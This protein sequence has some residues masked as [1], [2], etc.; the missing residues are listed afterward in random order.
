MP[1]TLARVKVKSASSS[2]VNTFLER[3]TGSWMTQALYVAAKLGI[4]DLLKNGP[5]TCED[6]AAA[7]STQASSLHR[8]LRALATI[9]ICNET[10][11]GAFTLAP[12]GSFLLTDGAS[13]LRSWTIWW[14]GHLW[15]AW[16]NL[17]HS[18]R[19]GKSARKLLTGKDGFDHLESNAE[20]A[21]LF[22]RAMAELTALNSRDILRVYDFSGF[23]RITDIGGGYGEFLLFILRQHPGVKGVVF[24]LPR[25][26]EGG[27]R[28]A[29]K[30]GLASRCEFLT[31][32]FFESI[33]GGADAYL[34]KNVLHDW[35]DEKSRQILENCRRS[36]D[37]NAR[38]LVIEQ[39]L[40]EQRGIS[41]AH[42]AISQN[43]LTM[44]VAHGAQ[45]RTE[46]EY[47]ALLKSAG[48]MITRTLQ[49]GTGICTIEAFPV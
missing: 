24:D 23:K 1:K 31:G 26:V 33:P 34:L 12:M 18:V 41:T 36:M 2:P 32:D 6:L 42:Q 43:D 11:D 44:L 15:P 13:S 30:A 27:R 47:K 38:L 4:A 22:D 46:R 3:L 21:A 39:L 28:H 9:E 14:G 35:N 45:E 16:G 19:T 8:L 48:F 49:T 5:K 7:T 37:K 17:L 20:T 10:E 29:K 25:A 40:P